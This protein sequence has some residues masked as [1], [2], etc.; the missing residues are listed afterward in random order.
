MTSQEVSS[1]VISMTIAKNNAES[2]RARAIG[3]TK[4]NLA[5]KAKAIEVDDDDTSSECSQEDIKCAL[6]KHLALASRD[7]CNKPDIKS[8]SRDNT[9]FNSSNKSPKGRS[10]YNYN[11]KSH[12]VAKCPFENREDNGGRLIRKIKSRPPHPLN[13]NYAI[14]NVTNKERAIVVH[15]EYLS[16]RMKMMMMKSKAERLWELLLLPLP[17]LHDCPSST[18]QMRT[19]SPPTKSVSW[20]RTTR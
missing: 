17:L 10:C 18:H 16:A 4:V 2:A 7:F 3:S 20:P 1:E 14:K 19:S 8:R 6:N 9:R 15:E 13:K 12:F 5:L 11:D